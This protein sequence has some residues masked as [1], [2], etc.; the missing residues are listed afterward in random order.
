MHL[1]QKLCK[2]ERIQIIFSYLVGICRVLCNM[3]SKT[4]FPDIFG[5]HFKHMLKKQQYALFLPCRI[6]F[7]F[8]QRNPLVKCTTIVLF[9][10][11][12]ILEV[13]IILQLYN[14]S[15]LINSHLTIERSC[16]NTLSLHTFSLSKT[17]FFST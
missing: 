6:N 5:G 1:S 15:V 17:L 8:L 9:S 12:A 14:F 4:G 13:F 11:T 16:F 2:T 10:V 7:F 3:F